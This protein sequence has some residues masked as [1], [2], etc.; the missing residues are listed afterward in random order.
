MNEFDYLK[1]LKWVLIVLLAGFIGQFGKSL[2]KHLMEKT[3]LKKENLAAGSEIST[4]SQTNN[5]QSE[6]FQKS[7]SEVLLKEPAKE[8]LSTKTDEGLDLEQAKEQ[9][10]MEKKALKA[11]VK[12]KKKETKLKEEG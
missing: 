8:Y 7:E 4:V 10:K 3:R 11:L 5:K 1:I 9:A 2:A 12:Q 6:K